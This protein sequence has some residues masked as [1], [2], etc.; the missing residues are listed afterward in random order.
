[1]AIDREQDIDEEKQKKDSTTTPR[2]MSLTEIPND[3]AGL[4]SFNM[5]SVAHKTRM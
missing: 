3:G 5:E 1:M 2:A 4:S